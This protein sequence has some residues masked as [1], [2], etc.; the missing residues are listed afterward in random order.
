M[1]AAPSGK[2]RYQVFGPYLFPNDRDLTH[3]KALRKFWAAR[4]CDGSPEGLCD[5]VGVY[6]WT[7]K[8]KD[9]RVP[10]NVGI[11]S[12]QGFK[13]RF[14]QKEASFLRLL[15]DRPKAE[16]EVYLLA[17]RTKRGRFS[18]TNQT[19]LNDW[20]ETLL[21]GSALNVNPSLRNTAKSKF[22]RTTVVEGYLN[23][24]AD[25]RNEA[26]ESFSAIFQQ[27]RERN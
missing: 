21:I 22:L 19:R 15:R 6:V 24:R 25:K 3:R 4:L 8:E 18:K 13:G 17:R 1:K 23:D 14:P 27:P 26:A 10:W 2:S 9:R 5:A 7:V 16:I 20:L 11:T 12:K